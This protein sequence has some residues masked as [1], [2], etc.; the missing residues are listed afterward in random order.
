M[1]GFRPRPGGLNQVLGHTTRWATALVER[2]SIRGRGLGGCRGTE[3]SDFSVAQCVEHESQQLA[4]DRDASLVLAAALGDALTARS[5]PPDR[6]P[7][8]PIVSG[9]VLVPPMVLAT[10]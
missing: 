5:L 8:V 1:T 9:L 4:G 6:R 10:I 3:A 7:Y 2:A